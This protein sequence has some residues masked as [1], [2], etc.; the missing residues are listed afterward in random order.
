MKNGLSGSRQ[1]IPCLYGRRE[2]GTSEEIKEARSQRVWYKLGLERD[3]EARPRR[4]LWP[5]FIVCPTAGN[6]RSF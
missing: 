1:H 5:E 2:G 6:N 4:A 3:T